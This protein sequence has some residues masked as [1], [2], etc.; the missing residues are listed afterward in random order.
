MGPSLS[1]DSLST[2][3][4]IEL[5]ESFATQPST[6][7]ARQLAE[8]GVEWFVV[9]LDKTTLRDWEPYAET[10]A[11]TWRFWILRLR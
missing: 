4:A 8:L 7:S 9:D 2:S 11:M 5:S 6:S 1:F 10:T 3:N